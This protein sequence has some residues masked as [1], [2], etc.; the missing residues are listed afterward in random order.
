MFRQFLTEKNVRHSDYLQTS[1][2]S[3]R[4]TKGLYS[5]QTNMKSDQTHRFR[6]PSIVAKTFESPH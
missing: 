4:A 6:V 5:L 3:K 1:V 2:F